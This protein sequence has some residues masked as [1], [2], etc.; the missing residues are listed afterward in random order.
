[1]SR[2]FKIFLAALGAVAT[3]AIV[4]ISLP[5]LWRTG[6][7]LT[8]QVGWWHEPE[9][10][11]RTIRIPPRQDR[12]DLGDVQWW[13]LDRRAQN[14]DACITLNVGRLMPYPD[15]GIGPSMSVVESSTA[16]EMCWSAEARGVGPHM[17]H[18]AFGRRLLVG[19]T[20]RGVNRVR[21]TLESG[22]VLFD[23]AGYLR[24]L[25]GFVLDLPAGE[26]VAAIDGICTEAPCPGWVHRAAVE[27][28]RA[29]EA[30]R[31]GG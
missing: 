27:R 19:V 6:W 11:Q 4:G 3:V 31:R 14:G 28:A 7:R 18:E 16:N 9:S 22:R 17:V 8:E 21:V 12:G 1:M 2:D 30:S 10:P 25:R 24:R 23:E 29:E 20:G 13:M 15:G 26:T 5:V